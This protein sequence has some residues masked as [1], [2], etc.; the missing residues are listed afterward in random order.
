MKKLLFICIAIFAINEMNAQAPAALVVENT[1]TGTTVTTATY[2]ADVDGTGDP[3]LVNGKYHYKRTTA[4]SGVGIVF[5]GTQWVNY[6]SNNYANIVFFQSTHNPADNGVDDSHQIAPDSGWESS[7]SPCSPTAVLNITSG[8]VLDIS[9]ELENSLI[10]V[11]PNPSSNFIKVSNLKDT[12]QCRITNITGQTVISTVLDTNN[13][14]IDVRDLARGFYFV[15]IEG[16][17]TI[18]LIKK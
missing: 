4:P 2:E 8:A 16:K 6:R 9:K 3:I 5:D 17:K 13:N 14:E 1:C 11:Y 18:K 10:T 7:G 15:E 12:V